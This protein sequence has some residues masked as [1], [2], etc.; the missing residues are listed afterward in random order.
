ML[1]DKLNPFDLN[2]NF[3]RHQL[4]YNNNQTNLHNVLINHQF[5]FLYL[6]WFFAVA[7][8]SLF[9]HSLFVFLILISQFDSI[10]ASLWCEKKHLCKAK[11]KLSK[12]CS[13]RSRSISLCLFLSLLHSLIHPTKKP[14]KKK[15]VVRAFNILAATKPKQCLLTRTHK[16]TWTPFRMY[17]CF[18]NHLPKL[19]L[20]SAFP[21]PG[22]NA[23][24]WIIFWIH[25][26]HWISLS[27]FCWHCT[28]GTFPLC[29]LTY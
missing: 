13:Y 21:P 29:T 27:I 26:H 16:H 17:C 12:M 6:I 1:D 9:S 23:L 5:H 10:S 15:V 19:L 14:D 8:F 22:S 25:L 18:K 28:T 7:L 11:K 4:S 24:K 3:L 2:F 20:R